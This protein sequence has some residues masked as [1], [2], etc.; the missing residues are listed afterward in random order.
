MYVVNT[1]INTVNIQEINCMAYNPY[2]TPQPVNISDPSGRLSFEGEGMSNFHFPYTPTVTNM[3]NANYTQVTPTHSNFQQQFFESAANATINVTAPIIIENV[4]QGQT[5]LNA[6]D[7][8]RGAMKMR[9]G[10]ND[11]QRG[12]P[13]PVLRFNAHGIFQNIPVL[14]NNFVYNLDA[15]VSYI[16]IVTRT[17]QNPETIIQMPVS[18][19]FVIDFLVSYSPK[20]VR[21]NFTL[22]KYLSGNL[23]GEGYV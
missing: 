14:V 17:E 7:F 11:S 21:E 10:K 2:T 23:R 4:E 18:G 16:D 12:L 20:N 1:M 9:F 8:F 19:T 13:P 6:L 3:V 15:D 5:I 22:D